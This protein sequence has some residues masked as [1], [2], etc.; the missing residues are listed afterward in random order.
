MD[1]GRRNSGTYLARVSEVK[2]YSECVD[3]SFAVRVVGV[4]VN[5][6]AFSITIAPGCVTPQTDPLHAAAGQGIT[7]WQNA[8][9]ECSRKKSGDC[10][11]GTGWIVILLLFV[12]TGPCLVCAVW[13]WWAEVKRREEAES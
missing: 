1:P 7:V 10:V 12:S 6:T 13:Q 4:A 11:R 8:R 3:E 2:L 9:G 5:V